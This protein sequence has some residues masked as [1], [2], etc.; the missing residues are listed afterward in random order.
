MALADWRYGGPPGG[1]IA[2]SAAAAY[3]GLYGLA[4]TSPAVLGAAC[5]AEK[6]IFLRENLLLS[7]ETL[8]K[9]G[10]DVNVDNVFFELLW[11]DEANQHFSGVAYITTPNL[12]RYLAPPLAWA[13][14]PG[15]AQD[16][17]QEHWHKMIMTVDFGEQAYVKLQCNEDVWSMWPL[18]Y[19]LAVVPI[20]Q[21]GLIRIGFTTA[22]AVAHTVYF[23]DVGVYEE[24]PKGTR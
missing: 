11:Y 14:V 4:V 21:Y 7:L 1:N 13:D 12:W 19:I 15:G 2:R 3:N 5:Y 18:P 17:A 6:D 23:D 8:F 16:L 22:A 20:P 24:Y 9:Y 10:L